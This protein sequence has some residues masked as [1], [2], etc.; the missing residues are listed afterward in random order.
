MFRCLS[1]SAQFD[2]H[3]PVCSYCFASHS[4]LPVARRPRAAI[5]GEMEL[6]DARSLTRAIWEGVDIPAYSGLEL[7][8]G[9]L[10]VL[11][12]AAGSGKS[13]MLAKLL[14]TLSGPAMLVSIEEPG[15]PSLALRLSRVGIKRSDL[16]IASRA[17][18]DQLASVIRERKLVAAG[19]DSVQRSFFEPR[20]LRH[21]LLTL[22]G[23]RVLFCTSQVN[24]QGS[25][26]GSEEL[27]H[28]ADV[29]LELENMAWTV[30]KSRYQAI[31]ATGPVL[32]EAEEG[33]QYG[34][35]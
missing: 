8:R 27:R 7:R 30:T 3:M 17:T 16:L 32:R 4:L 23:L 35:T 34:A 10:V 6:T 22:P 5:D 18:A 9:A 1:C 28:E 15:G 26:R 12:G 2:A 11:V 31:G 14:A 19:I 29:V 25:L 21:L 24:K 20:E 33:V 13:T